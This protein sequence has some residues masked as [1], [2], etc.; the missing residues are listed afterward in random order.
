MEHDINNG[1]AQ[2]FGITASGNTFVLG[3]YVNV[4][5][6]SLPVALRTKMDEHIGT[7][8]KTA[9][10]QW[11]NPYLEISVTFRP[12]NTG[13]KSGAADKIVFLPPGCKVVMSGLR[14][15]T[16]A[17][18]FDGTHPGSGYLE[19]ILN[20]ATGWINMGD[21]TITLTKDSNAE[22]QLTL[23]HYFGQQALLLTKVA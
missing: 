21:A 14:K 13:S 16:I 20:D 2:V 5:A 17:T 15:I 3:G 10:I 8:G 18:D 22:V 4:F 9:A 7:S 23:R 11:T 6:D 1:H 19:D 12:A